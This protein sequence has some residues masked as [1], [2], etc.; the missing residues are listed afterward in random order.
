VN[1]EARMTNDESRSRAGAGIR[2][3]NF[4]LRSS[5]VVR[6]LSL[7]LLVAVLFS[8]TV[9]SQNSIILSSNATPPTVGMEGQLDVA[10]PLAGLITKPGDHRAPMLVRIAATQPYGT[11]TRYDLRYTG[12]V[13]GNHDL[14]DYLFTADGFPPTNLPALKIVVVGLLPTPD[15]GWLAEQARHPPSVF[16]GYRATLAVIVALWIVAFVVFW[17]VGRH[18]KSVAPG[19]P[20][21]RAPTFAERIRPLVE[22]AAAGTLSPD[23]KA[24]LERMLITHWQQRLEL[25]DASGDELIARLRQHNEAGELLRALE[26]WLHR[27]PGRGEVQVENFLAPYRHLAD[28]QPAQATG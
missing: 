21:Q 25:T 3:W 1:D 19:P 6:H 10:L 27:P 16:G 12:R 8:S 7:S 28:E 24:T 9:F 5:F 20:V 22:R 11:L 14:R 17:R 26:D 15:N 13:P 23:E 4:G 2:L 18:A